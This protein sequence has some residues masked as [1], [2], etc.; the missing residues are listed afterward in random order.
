M[1]HQYFVATRKAL[2]ARKTPVFRGNGGETWNTASPLKRG[3]RIM[4]YTNGIQFCEAVWDGVAR[5]NWRAPKVYF[6]WEKL[7]VA[8]DVL[9]P[10]T[11]IRNKIVF[12]LGS[13]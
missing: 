1:N 5:C 12:L 13:I 3:E 4:I 10:H 6:I 9:Q 11:F 8:L 7:I 2:V